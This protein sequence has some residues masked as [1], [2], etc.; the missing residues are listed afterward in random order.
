[1]NNLILIKYGELTTKKANRN[2]FIRRLANNIKN[3]LNG[4]EFSIKFD[5]VRMYIECS[6]VDS[7]VNKLKRVFG[8]H[9][10]VICHKVNTNID[11]I[12]EKVLE[13]LKN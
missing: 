10:I 1:M 9:G 6:N 7:I 4:E 11:T 13:L 5:R 12:K 3:I 2:E 8:I